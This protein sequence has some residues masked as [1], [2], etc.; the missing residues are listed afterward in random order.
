MAALVADNVRSDNVGSALL[1]SILARMK[2]LG[3]H[4]KA[5]FFVGMAFE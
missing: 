1:S 2:M 4:S 3:A 5:T